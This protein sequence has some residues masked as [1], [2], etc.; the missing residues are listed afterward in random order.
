M[1]NWRPVKQRSLPLRRVFS[2]CTSLT[3]SNK[4]ILINHLPR[5]RLFSFPCQETT[6]TVTSYFFLIKFPF[7]EH[8]TIYH[9]RVTQFYSP[10]FQCDHI[11]RNFA[12]LAILSPKQ[13]III[14]C[15]GL[16]IAK[17]NLIYG[18]YCYAMGQ[19]FIIE[20]GQISNRLSGHCVTPLPTQISGEK[21]ML[22]IK[23]WSQ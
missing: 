9:D 7:N 15:L 18:K 6:I 13:F 12:T 10:K 19:I 5:L 2:D 16:K 17:V 21:T 3:K 8:H 11:W 22:Q 4:N 14:N 20:N 23:I 1:F